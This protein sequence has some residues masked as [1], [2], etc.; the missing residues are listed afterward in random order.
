MQRSVAS[1]KARYG[2]AAGAML[3]PESLAKRQRAHDRNKQVRQ[4]KEFS[5]WYSLRKEN[6]RN[7]KDTQ[8]KIFFEED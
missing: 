2:S 8:L 6:Y 5:D 3:S 4:T 7:P 1:R